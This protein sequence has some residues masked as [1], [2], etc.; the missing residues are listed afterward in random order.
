M[1]SS[2]NLKN[3][4]DGKPREIAKYDILLGDLAWDYS[5]A[6]AS[7][8][9]KRSAV[10]P[11]SL[12]K[13]I[14]TAG[15]QHSPHSPC[16]SGSGVSQKPIPFAVQYRTNEPDAVKTESPKPLIYPKF[17]LQYDDVSIRMSPETQLR[18]SQ[19]AADMFRHYS[20]RQLQQSVLGGAVGVLVKCA[21]CC[22]RESNSTRCAADITA[23]KPG[24]SVVL[25]R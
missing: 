3:S 11:G 9:G 18:H 14:G 6:D 17:A 13:S 23:M 4:I 2:T 22:L 7:R 16:A 12:E 1:D 19:A 10:M 21:E 25:T 8:V 20:M 5:V 24:D 15:N